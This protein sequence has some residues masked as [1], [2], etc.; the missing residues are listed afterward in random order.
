M[1]Y[2]YKRPANVVYTLSGAISPGPAFETDVRLSNA[3][4][5]EQ[6]AI[7]GVGIELPDIDDYIDIICDWAAPQA[8]GLILL[9]KLSCPAG[10]RI[11]VTGRRLGDGGYTRDLGGNSDYRTAE[12]E[13]GR[14]QM[15]VFPSAAETDYIGIQVR[16]YNDANGVTWA[17]DGTDL[18]IGEIAPYAATKLCSVPRRS[19]G[20]SQRAATERAVN[21]A[22]H[23]TRRGN[24]RSLS[25]T[26]RGN[27]DDAYKSGLPGG[28]DIGM[29][30]SMQDDPMYRAAIIP[31]GYGEDGAPDYYLIQRSAMFAWVKWGQVQE[32]DAYR[33][34]AASLEVEEVI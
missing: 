5:S 1:I 19:Q 24:F 8:M 31:R 16:I 30:R 17:D 33:R 15:I 18:L 10:T 13:D 28:I 21:A 27:I 22:L 4:P 6:T 2:G 23:A 14:V 12:T 26:I 9:L 20:R 32:E 7:S 29:L 34:F 11:V 25:V 3:Q